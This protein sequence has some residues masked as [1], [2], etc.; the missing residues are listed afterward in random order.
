MRRA[1]VFKFQKKGK[2]LI[3][4]VSKIK[5]GGGIATEPFIWVDIQTPPDVIIM[6]IFNALKNSKSDLPNPTNWDKQLKGFLSAI[7]LKSHSE[8]YDN[9]INVEILEKDKK[10]LFTPTKNKGIKGG[11]INDSLERI[12]VDAD[13]SIS[14]LSSKFELAL[15]QSK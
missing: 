2:Y 14:E 6:H 11:F 12:E 13:Q 3:H 7:G 5:M 9:V 4:S 15:S 8:L 10:I 1:S